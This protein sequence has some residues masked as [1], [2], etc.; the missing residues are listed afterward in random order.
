MPRA[1]LNASNVWGSEF[2]QS[3]KHMLQQGAG[4]GMLPEGSFGL[5]NLALL[6]DQELPGG[7]QLVFAFNE[8]ILELI[9]YDPGP[10]LFHRVHLD[11]TEYAA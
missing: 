11:A 1:C 9:E 10:L 5:L 4:E 8:V 6:P 2:F 7:I 3:I